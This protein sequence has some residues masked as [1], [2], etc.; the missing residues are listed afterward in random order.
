IPVQT[1]FHCHPEGGVLAMAMTPDAKYVATI[2]AEA[3]QVGLQIL[4]V[5][6]NPH[7]SSAVVCHPEGVSS[8]ACSYDG[9][10]VFTA[11][12]GDFTVFSWETN[13]KSLKTIFIIASCELKVEDMLNEVKFSKY[14][15]TGKYV[16]DIDLADLL[17]LYINHRP[18]FGISAYELQHAF[19]VLGLQ[20]ENCGNALNRGELL[21][22][23]QSTGEHMTEEE[24]A[25]YFSTLLG[26]NPEGGRS[27]LG[28][29]DSAGT[30][31]KPTAAVT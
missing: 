9:K 19:E 10:Y 16:I 2:G 8:F 17:K 15:D 7:K 21:Q 14:V 12:G 18:A 26:L 3:A 29:Y 20:N 5:D 30:V 6:G 24:L 4:P 23:L 27:E 22:L 28:N 1:L 25:E 31:N 11:G 13:M